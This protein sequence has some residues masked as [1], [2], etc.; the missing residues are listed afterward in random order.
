MEVDA[1]QHLRLQAQFSHA[2]CGEIA[3]Q[4]VVG[5]QQSRKAVPESKKFLHRFVVVTIVLIFTTLRVLVLFVREIGDYLD[6][7]RS[8]VPP[9]NVFHSKK[10]GKD[11]YVTSLT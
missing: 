6:F 9:F 1:L 8:V 5:T 7:I 3:Q 11:T 10:G 2:L 4:T